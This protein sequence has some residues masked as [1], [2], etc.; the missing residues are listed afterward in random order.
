M[1]LVDLKAE[2]EKRLSGGRLTLS[3]DE[4]L[5]G[6]SQVLEVLPERRLALSGVQISLGEGSGL[7]VSGAAE[8]PWPIPGVA[9]PLQ[10]VQLTLVA[11]LSATGEWLVD[12]ELTA[13]LELA[14]QL[15]PVI[16]QAPAGSAWLVSL[17]ADPTVAASMDELFRLM[18][19]SRL[20]NLLPAGFD[21]QAANLALRE[22]ELQFH[23]NGNMRTSLSYSLAASGEWALLPN[24]LTLREIGVTLEAEYRPGARP[25]FAI[26]ERGTLRGTVQ[27]GGTAY[28]VALGLGNDGHA[29][30]RIASLPGGSP[31]RLS[32]L[33]DLIGLG[34]DGTDL[35]GALADL[36]FA[37]LRLDRLLLEADLPGRRVLAARLGGQVMLGN[38]ALDFDMRYPELTLG[39]G[40]SPE[41]QVDLKALLQHFGVSMPDLPALTLSELSAEL[42]LRDRTV[43]THAAVTGDLR[44]KVGNVDVALQELELDLAITPAGPSA[45]LSGFTS[46]DGAEC[47]AIVELPSLAV[48]LGLQQGSVLQLKQLINGLVPGELQLPDDLPEVA[49]T[50]FHLEAAPRDGTFA[51]QGRVRVVGDQWHLPVGRTALALRELELELHRKREGNTHK[52]GARLGA[53]VEL[54]RA[55]FAATVELPSLAVTAGLVPGSPLNLIGLVEALLPGEVAVPADVPEI[56]LSDLSLSGNPRGRTFRLTAR[57]TAK[58]PGLCARVNRLN[59]AVT[60]LDLAM[61]RS[62]QRTFARLYTEIRVDDAPFSFAFQ[63]PGPD[64]AAGLQAGGTLNLTRA[65]SRL[66]PE[67]LVMPEGLPEITFNELQLDLQPSKGTFAFTAA[68]PDT[69]PIPIGQGLSVGKLSLTAKAERNESGAL[70]PSGELSGTVSLGGTDVKALVR[71][72]ARDLVVRTEVP[73]LRLFGLL[74]SVMG[75]ETLR[76]LPVPQQVWDLELSE[77]ATE[78]APLIPRFV[79]SAAAPGFERLFVVVQ[80]GKGSAGFTAGLIAAPSWQFSQLS[81]ALSPLDAIKFQRTYVILS[82][83]NNPA[84]PA[85]IAG[86]VA[87][88]GGAVAIHRGVNFSAAID[89]SDSGLKDLIGLSEVDMLGYF[90][91]VSMNA[92]LKGGVRGE[93]ELGTP[94][95]TLKE[96]GLFL[97]LQGNSVAVGLMTKVGL[98]VYND[99]LTFGGEIG[100]GTKSVKGTVNMLGTWNNPLGAQGLAIGDVGLDLGFTYA[101]R[102]PEFG[103]IGTTRIGSVSTTA[104]V[105]FDSGDPTRC[106][107]QMRL[108]NLKLGELL[109]TLCQGLIATS[110]PAELKQTINTA[111]FK[112]AEIYIAPQATTVGGIACEQGIRLKGDVQF[113]DV[114]ARAQAE[115]SF[116]QG[117]KLNAEISKDIE[118]G[119]AFKLT[120]LEPG[121]TPHLYVEVPAPGKLPVIDIEGNLSL[122]KMTSQR[123][124]LQVR[125]SGFYFEQETRLFNLLYTKLRVSGGLQN[126][127]AGIQVRGEFRDDLTAVVQQ[128][129]S[130]VLHDAAAAGK[131][132]L[133]GAQNLCKA[134]QDRIA[135]LNGQINT[136]MVQTHNTL[137]QWKADIERSKLD[138]Q[139]KRAQVATWA[140]A[141][142]AARRAAQAD[143]DR[144]VAYLWS[145]ERELQWA[146]GEVNRI[147]SEIRA[148]EAW[149]NSLDW[150]GQLINALATGIK[151]AALWAAHATATL[152]LQGVAAVVSAARAVVQSFNIELDPR[153]LA[154]KVKM[155]AADLALRIAE[156]LLQGL[157]N[158]LTDAQRGFDAAFRTLSD[159]LAAAYRVL[160]DAQYG[161]E[162]VKQGLEIAEQFL[163]KVVQTAGQVLSVREAVFDANLDVL[164]G[165][166]I[167]V[168]ATVV[169]LGNPQQIRW[170]FNFNSPAESARAVA[171][172]LLGRRPA[173]VAAIA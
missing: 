138:V 98:R 163:D 167:T 26:T 106:L 115:V 146:Q 110:I 172:F 52:V 66:L 134:A 35:E 6:F 94:D 152:V 171:E 63:L 78:L 19:G 3:P 61:E 173:A 157:I 170:Q 47:Y 162:K 126:G 31:I 67:E 107:L 45:R 5:P 12:A 72:G 32:D 130:A 97:R 131:S 75:A 55:A 148:T 108:Q 169:Y 119:D 57:A 164:R 161:L 117:L 44:V 116:D 22:L 93:F 25:R 165:G 59:V 69:W 53:R 33:A 118:V 4:G 43:V 30:V 83:A 150:F 17:K 65:V 34:L 109:E 84:L 144:A 92:E 80:G 51:V 128:Y 91:P 2:L 156:G 21:A 49:V 103:I 95:A 70:V 132:A 111:N 87:A 88:G 20:A 129:A 1:Q 102:V 153:V 54:A 89:L 136:L 141:V 142:D 101:T 46:V 15:Y 158:G 28:Q 123:T 23:P 120:G 166:Q 77:I 74:E 8:G 50:G 40:L 39:G 86:Q 82:S 36:G 7:I 62:P 73:T 81:P 155:A 29:L 96:V 160:Q 159:L 100:V 90:D 127:S 168:V 114:E 48:S 37:G 14:G 60:E 154:E 13:G 85:E 27:L 56:I 121:R 42:S 99:Q 104:A 147:L 68:S 122:L 137:D 41:S 140:A 11:S 38:V 139:N 76:S 79:A 151:L 143:K 64:L 9:V 71:L 105:K 16:G 133:T 135:D 18:P 112:E 113:W 124:K 145:R 24:L 58:A 149:F 125:D 10:A